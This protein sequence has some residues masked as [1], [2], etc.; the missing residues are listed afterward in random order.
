MLATAPG[1]GQR[2]EDKPREGSR[3][4][5]QGGH[6]QGP[7]QC[8]GPAADRGEGRGTPLPALQQRPA[9]MVR[10]V[11]GLHLGPVQAEPALLQ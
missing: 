8:P 2:C 3:P 4:A 9:H 7:E 6:H 11:W 1:E 5:E 10:P